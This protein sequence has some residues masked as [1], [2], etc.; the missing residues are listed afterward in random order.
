MEAA[1]LPQAGELL[2]RYPHQLSGGMCQRVLIAMAFAS[3]PRLVIADEPTTA[4]DVTIQAPIV[5]LIAEMQRRTAR[6]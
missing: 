5:R 1:H 3:N 6:R 2:R 4:L